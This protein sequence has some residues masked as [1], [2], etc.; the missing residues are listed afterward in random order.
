MNDE[1]HGDNPGLVAAWHGDNDI[2]PF[3]KVTLHRAG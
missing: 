3:N 1:N 2:G